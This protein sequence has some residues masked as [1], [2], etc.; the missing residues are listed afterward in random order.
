MQAVCAH[1]ED[2]S[3]DAGRRVR[4]P[5]CGELVCPG[6]RAMSTPTDCQAFS[7]DSALAALRREDNT[8]S[9]LGLQPKQEW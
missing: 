6:C 9:L 2:E 5:A 7:D 3:G 1:C 8:R 4:C